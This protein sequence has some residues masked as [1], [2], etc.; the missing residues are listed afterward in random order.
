MSSPPDRHAAEHALAIAALQ[1]GDLTGPELARALELRASCPDCSALYVDLGTLRSAVRAMPAPPRRRDFRLT[2]EDA[3]R[4]RPTGWRRFVGWLAAPRSSVRPL[5]TGLTTLGL[6]G[7]LL[8]TVPGL[9]LFGS[10][11]MLSAPESRDAGWRVDGEMA[12]G[13]PVETDKTVTLAAPSG[14]AATAAPA[15]AP[16]APAAEPV[17]TGGVAGSG[18]EDYRANQGA[19][20]GTPTPNAGDQGLLAGQQPFGPSL[21]ALASIVLLITGLSLFAAR[22][23]L[24]RSGG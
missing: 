24:R 9:S 1:A 18:S 17:P 16:E 8:A 4:L 6:A 2:E 21:V 3:A 15:G 14:P 22:W 20:P 23:A 10:A 11:T 5:A 13:A 7:L 12:T 19:T